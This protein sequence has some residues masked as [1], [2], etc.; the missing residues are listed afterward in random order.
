MDDYRLAVFNFRWI[1]ASNQPATNQRTIVNSSR[2][3]LCEV[4]LYVTSEMS[5]HYAV[6]A[7]M[8][9]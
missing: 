9:P 2:R 5:V 6:I 1:F 3:N 7:V 8:M 4:K